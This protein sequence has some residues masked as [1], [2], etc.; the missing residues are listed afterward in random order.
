VIGASRLLVLVARLR[1][2]GV[3]AF[4][5]YRRRPRHARDR[6][7]PPPAG[8][9][10]RAIQRARVRGGGRPAGILLSSFVGINPPSAPPSPRSADVWCDGISLVGSLVAVS[11]SGLPKRTLLLDPGSLPSSTV[12]SI[13]L[14]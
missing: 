2:R 6:D 1:F 13:V 11:C 5:R 8:R 14:L 7:A 3:Y 4:L 10:R 12:F 9:H